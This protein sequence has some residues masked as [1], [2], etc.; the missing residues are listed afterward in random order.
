MQ[1]IG[2]KATASVF[3]LLAST[4]TGLWA[5]FDAGMQAYKN[6]DFTTARIE[7]TQDAN[8]GHAVAQYYLGDIY[9]GGYSVTPDPEIA[10][11]W[12]RLAA[13]QGYAPAQRRMGSIYAKGLGVIQD[14]AEA[15]RWYYAAAE[16]GDT[17][18][19]Y[20]IGFSYRDGNGAPMEIVEAYKWWAI[21][22]L[23]GDPDAGAERDR[24]A[25]SMSDVDRSRAQRFANAWLPP[26]NRSRGAGSE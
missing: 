7:W 14:P 16:G 17:H 11:K 24:L 15:F 12:Y 23:W 2:P 8:K 19:Q 22:A 5:D 25:G 21:A 3:A 26:S 18:A 20:M 9:S 4:G 1:G 10:I 6:L 13:D